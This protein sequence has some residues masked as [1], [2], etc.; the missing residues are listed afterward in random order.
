MDNPRPNV[1][2]RS[3]K[4]CGRPILWAKSAETGKMVPLD[5]TAPIY[6]LSPGNVEI[7]VCTRIP[8]DVYAVSHLATCPAANQYSGKSRSTT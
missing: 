6:M 2:L 5:P 8:R 4:G 3:C 7:T 1:K